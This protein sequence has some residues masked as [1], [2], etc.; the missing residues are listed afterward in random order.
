KD[1]I[2]DLIGCKR[3]D[4]LLAS[5]K[6]GEGVDEILSAIVQRI[7][8]PS[9]NADAPL[10][11]LIFDSVF[12]SYRGVIIYFRIFNG[13]IQKGDH[14]KFFNTGKE[15]EVEEVGVLLL[16][17]APRE[18]ISTG[19]VGYVITGIKDAG[20]VKVGDTI[21]H[22]DHPAAEPIKGFEEVKP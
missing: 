9:G 7:P 16:E 20:E 6:T 14:I 1:Q 17:R 18:K 2:V 21:T 19:D 15:Y 3:E 10:Q 13:E 4:I 11:A 5:G 8:A 12:N 22:A